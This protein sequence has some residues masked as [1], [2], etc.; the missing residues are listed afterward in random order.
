MA[1]SDDAELA[2]HFEPL[3]TALRDN[4]DKIVAEIAGSEGK[5]V[6]LGGYYRPDADKRAAAMRPSSTLN[7]LIG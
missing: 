5:S 6:D 2:A 7:G 3:A 1:Q 4:E